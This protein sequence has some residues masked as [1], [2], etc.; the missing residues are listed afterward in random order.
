MWY[1]EIGIG[2]LEYTYFVLYGF[3]EG[4]KLKTLI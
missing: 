3:K 4:I 1:N 2:T